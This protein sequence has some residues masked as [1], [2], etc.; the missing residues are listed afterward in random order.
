MRSCGRGSWG[1]RGLAFLAALISFLDGL[2]DLLLERT[3]VLLAAVAI[4]NDERGTAEL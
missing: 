4:S 1:A 3:L 2:I